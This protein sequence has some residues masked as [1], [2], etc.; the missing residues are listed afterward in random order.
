MDKSPVAVHPPSGELT[1][2]YR[3]VITDEQFTLYDKHDQVVSSHQVLEWKASQRRAT[4][5]TPEGRWIVRDLCGCN[6]R[7][8]ALKAEWNS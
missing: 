8:R 2:P 6:S 4:I 7:M 3:A 1:G 5:E